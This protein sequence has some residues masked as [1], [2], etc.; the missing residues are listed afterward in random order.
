[1]LF[2]LGNGRCLLKLLRADPVRAQQL[3]LGKAAEVLIPATPRLVAKGENRAPFFNQNLVEWRSDPF[4]D[5][6]ILLDA[7]GGGP[8]ITANELGTKAT[9]FD[10]RSVKKQMPI[11][12]IGKKIGRGI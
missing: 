5:P 11:S 2:G 7:P 8:K 12:Q 1:M 4:T 9:L 6:F 3:T 10:P